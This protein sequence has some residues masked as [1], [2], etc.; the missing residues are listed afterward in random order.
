MSQ[1][2][3]TDCAELQRFLVRDQEYV[4][5]ITLSIEELIY[6]I[7]SVVRRLG[8]YPYGAAEYCNG[9]RI[10]CGPA[11]VREDSGL[12]SV[13][14]CSVLNTG[15]HPRTSTGF[16]RN[17]APAVAVRLYLIAEPF[18]SYCHDTFH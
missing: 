11:I 4:R 13:F 10:V 12:F 17:L 5:S 7:V 15:Q 6:P 16:R 1:A 14:N 8:C 3:K 18:D 2:A 9:Q